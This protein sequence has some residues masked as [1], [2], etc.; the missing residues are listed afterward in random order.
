MIGK[1]EYPQ[2]A[3]IE[4]RC[5]GT[6]DGSNEPVAEVSAALDEYEQRGVRRVVAPWH[7]AGFHH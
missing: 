4:A 1:D 7:P 6:M 3:G 2:T 5:C